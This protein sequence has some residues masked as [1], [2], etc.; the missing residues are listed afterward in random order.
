MLQVHAI[1]IMTGRVDLDVFSIFMSKLSIHRK[2]KQR[3]VYLRV[4]S[5]AVGHINSSR[6]ISPSSKLNSEAFIQIFCTT[7][8]SPG[9]S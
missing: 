3:I 2:N 9:D 4:C 8:V 5:Q 1:E 6:C 7:G